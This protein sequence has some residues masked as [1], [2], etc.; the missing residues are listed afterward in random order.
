MFFVLSVWPHLTVVPTRRQ[1]VRH[2]LYDG[3]RHDQLR[4]KGQSLRVLSDPPHWTGSAIDHRLRSLTYKILRPA[5]PGCFYDV[6]SCRNRPNL[7]KA[8]ADQ[9]SK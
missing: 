3:P 1:Y 6:R 9:I 7:S 8:A 4:K 2:L 5:M